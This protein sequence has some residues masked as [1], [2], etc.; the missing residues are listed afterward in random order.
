MGLKVIPVRDYHGLATTT[1][2]WGGQVVANL[3]DLPETTERDRFSIQVGVNLHVDTTDSPTRYLNH[4]C[5]PNLEIVGREVRAR[6]N[7]VAHDELTFNYLTTEWDMAEP[8]ECSCGAPDCRKTIR[9]YRYLWFSDRRFLDSTGEHLREL[10]FRGATLRDLMTNAV[11]SLGHTSPLLLSGGVDSLSILA[12]QLELGASPD[13]Y[14]F[15]LRGVE[16]SDWLTA[17]QIA[18]EFGLKFHTVWIEEDNL[19]QDVREII[20]R[21]GSSLKVWVQCAYP[22]QYVFPQ[23]QAD[24]VTKI[25]WGVEAGSLLGDGRQAAVQAKRRTVE[26][27]RELRYEYWWSDRSERGVVPWAE[28]LGIEMCDP[29][30]DEVLG[31]FLLSIPWEQL[32]KPKPKEILQ[33]AFPEFFSIAPFRKHSSYQINS[34][35]RDL[36]DTL[37]EGTGHQA[38]VAVYN[39]I[40]ADLESPRLF[41]GGNQ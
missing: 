20:E 10:E 30:R 3:D 14:T 12:A 25:L 23:L 24:G 6:R 39:R 27:E 28:S 34:G 21:I 33:E 19:I 31:E 26:D 13:I 9:G 16:S 5:D 29:Y 7:I 38:V 22:F 41:E 35:I 1:P 15:R 37:L 8:F 32:Q 11:Y 36:H 17:K 40:A 4:S 2:I 18:H